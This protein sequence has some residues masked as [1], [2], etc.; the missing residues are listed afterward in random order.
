MVLNNQ[1]SGVGSLRDTIASASPGDTIAFASDVTGTITLTSGTLEITK[2]VDIEGPGANILSKSGNNASTVFTVGSGV[3][4]TIAGLTIAD[5]NAGPDGTG[6]GIDNEEGATLT[7]TNCT[8]SGNS[9]ESGDG[10]ISDYGANCDDYLVR[11]TLANT[12]VG[13]NLVPMDPDAQGRFISQGYNLIGN[14]SSASGFVSSDLLNVRPYW[15]LC[16]ITAPQPR[17]SGDFD[18]HRSRTSAFTR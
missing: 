7:V 8:V 14:S 12:I 2:N 5:G 18:L 9:A 17:R 15:G 1:D 16:K 13:G 6:G 4:A 10:G 11:T 3:T